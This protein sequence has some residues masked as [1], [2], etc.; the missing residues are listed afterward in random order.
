MGNVRGY[1]HLG[2]YEPFWGE[3]HVYRGVGR[4][5]VI[6]E[7]LILVAG[8]IRVFVLATDARGAWYPCARV[9]IGDE[10]E[11]SRACDWSMGRGRWGSCG[12]GRERTHHCRLSFAVVAGACAGDTLGCDRKHVTRSV[13][14]LG[15]RCRIYLTLYF[16]FIIRFFSVERKRRSSLEAVVVVTDALSDRSFFCSVDAGCG[17]GGVGC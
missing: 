15:S 10:Q 2:S 14:H 17:R 16:I 1:E 5:L 8:V 11:R 4:A 3:F 7:T 6:D 9:A 13:T 12:R